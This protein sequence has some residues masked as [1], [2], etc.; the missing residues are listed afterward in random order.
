[1]D[2]W[3]ILILKTNNTE[4]LLSNTRLAGK[5][6]LIRFMLT[7]GNSLAFLKYHKST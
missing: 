2:G 5:A 6:E 1:M 7:N 3:T 4:V